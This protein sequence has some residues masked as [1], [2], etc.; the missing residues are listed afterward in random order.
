VE[1][2]NM[3]LMTVPVKTKLTDEAAVQKLMQR[4][5]ELKQN[6]QPEQG[7]LCAPQNAINRLPNV[8]EKN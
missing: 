1:E 5:E 6:Y 2:S 4:V 3:R 7:W 8:K